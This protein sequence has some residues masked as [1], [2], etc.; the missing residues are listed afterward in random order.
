MLITFNFINIFLCI[1][2]FVDIFVDDGLSISVNRRFVI[3]SYQQSLNMYGLFYD[4]QH[5]FFLFNLF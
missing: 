1:F 3:F 5:K 2:F 4:F